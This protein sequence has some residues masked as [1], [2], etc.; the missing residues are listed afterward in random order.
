MH[1]F[2]IRLIEF[3]VLFDV[4]VD[5]FS[6]S[7]ISRLRLRSDAFPSTDQI[8][9]QTHF[10][11]SSS[12]SSSSSDSSN[13]SLFEQAFGVQLQMPWDNNV[14]GDDA[15]KSKSQHNEQQGQWFQNSSSSSQQTSI[16]KTTSATYNTPDKKRKP[17]VQLY[18]S[19][20]QVDITPDAEQSP[21][22]SE[23]DID[24][25]VQSAMTAAK[26]MSI[27]T[28]NSDQKQDKRIKKK[29]AK[30][31]RTPKLG[32]LLIDHGSK[33]KASNEHL[34]SVAKQYH[35]SL[36]GDNDDNNVIVKAAHMEIAEPSILATLRQLV[37]GHKVTKVVCVPYFLS[38]GKHATIDVPNLISDAIQVLEEEGLLKYDGGVI[39]ITSS[40]ALGSNVESM[41]GVVDV[42]VETKLD[43]ESG[44]DEFHLQR[45]VNGE[46]ENSKENTSKRDDEIRK[47][48]NRVT[49]L[50]RMLQVKVDDLKTMTN[51][52][53]VLEDVAQKLQSRLKT[54]QENMLEKQLMEKEEADVKLANL[55]NTIDLLKEERDSLTNQIEELSLQQQLVEKCHNATVAKL[56]ETIE[57]SENKIKLQRE[58]ADEQDQ[59]RT[60]MSK[61]E[62]DDM[63]Q[64]THRQEEKVK[65]L[66]K[67]LTDLL[68]A[69][70]EL[71]QLQN[72]TEVVVLD[73]KDELK[74]AREMFESEL[75]C[76]NE[77][78]EDYKVKWNELQLQL[79]EERDRSTKLLDET[80]SK[81]EN[82]LLAE[83]ETSDDWKLK[84]KKLSEELVHNTNDNTTST[85]IDEKSDSELA[86]LTAQLEE[87]TA[88]SKNATSNIRD[89]EAKLQQQEQ[90]HE[91][92][93]SKREEQQAQLQKYLQAELQRYYKTIQNQ[94]AQIDSYKMEVTNMEATHKESI[95]IATNSVEASQKREMDMLNT[96]E[97]LEGELSKVTQEKE[98]GK[99]LLQKLQ[100]QLHELEKKA[101]VE[102]Q[103]VALQPAPANSDD[104]NV[105]DSN[106]SKK[107]DLSK[108]VEQ[109][110]SQV[111]AL[112]SE[113]RAKENLASQIEVKRSRWKK[114]RRRIFK[115]WTM[116]RR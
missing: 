97:E 29:P 37:T 31:K 116:F 52:V 49:L 39:E 46:K 8:P 23:E 87:A 14:D 103:A 72:D 94:T 24:N 98:D 41:L 99:K 77:K 21:K 32:I 30:D 108:I 54:E 50:E 6:H 74:R 9:I 42:L 76:E 28:N 13:R 91:S 35:S 43:E 10:S 68:D 113:M 4:V 18:P 111:E 65:Q 34:H 80:E 5:A 96:I 106:E 59:K 15:K 55:T 45:K 20:L 114:W 84:W 71:E 27:N 109:L 110:Q 107:E 7:Q 88:A 40:K 69:Y 56:Q 12:S 85:N 79:E 93:M 66:Q 16:P 86:E 90:E 36:V 25:Y 1:K 70:N 33:R 44:G 64:K 58:A 57:S 11:A 100:G 102:A 115:P 17:R 26:E 82:L 95:L 53:T 60:E 89:L 92:T 47:Y 101:E 81:Y 51:R 3:V 105:E 2:G 112:A 61:K 104:S 67:Q 83:R 48:T 73:Y 78:K 75:K 22:H 62:M 63:N 38:P 19:A